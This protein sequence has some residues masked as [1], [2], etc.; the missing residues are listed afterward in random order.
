MRKN[1]ASKSGVFNPLAFA[2]CSVGI[3]LA[4]FSLAASPSN[5][6][7]RS[8]VGTTQERV[9]VGD[10]RTATVR[11]G[12][13]ATFERSLGTT[14]SPLSGPV[15]SVVLAP[16]P[17]TAWMP[18]DINAAAAA[19]TSGN[20]LAR[21]SASA[22]APSGCSSPGDDDK[23]ED[24]VT[25][26]AP[27]V[28]GVAFGVNWA[29]AATMSPDGAVEYITGYTSP[30]INATDGGDFLTTAIEV[31]TGRTLWQMTLD[32]SEFSDFGRYIA[33]SPDGAEVVVLGQSNISRP[34][35]G[36]VGIYDSDLTVVAYNAATGQQLWTATYNDAD[37]PGDTPLGVAFSADSTVAVIVGA[38][39]LVS[40][41]AD[42]F[43]VAYSAATGTLQWSYLIAGTGNQYVNNV[44]AAGANVYTLAYLPHPGEAGNYD[45]VATCYY[46]STGD[47]RWS[48]P[49]NFGISAQP[50]GL[51]ID[52]ADSRLF[53]VSIVPFQS[54]GTQFATTAYDAAT[55][56]NLWIARHK[57]DYADG[58]DIPTGIAAGPEITLAN[59][60]RQARVYVTGLVTNTGFGDYDFGTIAYDAATGEQLFDARYGTDRDERAWAITVSADGSRVYMAGRNGPP[61]NGGASGGGA[62]D[63]M[64]ISYD[65]VTGQ[66][67]WAARY[68][69]PDGAGGGDPVGVNVSSDGRW[70]VTA[71]ALNYTDTVAAREHP[72]DFLALGYAEPIAPPLV[73]VKSRKTHGS[74]GTFDVD[75]PLIGTSGIECRS[76]GANGDYKLV[77]TFLNNTSV[78][79]VS[80]TSG[81]G[82]VSSSSIG[83]NPN[84]YTVNL[85]AV[86]NA[87]YLTVML[88]GALDSTGNRG[89]V[90]G[91]KMGVL[92]GDV[93]ASG[94]V[95]SGDTNLCK[96]Q[97]LQQVTNTNFRN[98]I[99]ASGAITTGDVNLIKQNA[100]SHL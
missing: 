85:T 15:A 82:T 78:A 33:V 92:V 46:S 38:V 55:G 5:G 89:N 91:P 80:V 68:S 37:K 70:V 42:G 96:A 1:S 50:E 74:A 87:Q 23:C 51:A 60:S 88:N 18:G 66:Q 41:D 39:A 53:A 21:L 48:T 47:V 69:L 16:Q 65:G 73:S 54:N 28:A 19:P 43:V 84:Q 90:V 35:P 7:T 95:T 25:A 59:G 26:I 71:G 22:I 14:P 52:P 63:L 9:A 36:S 83:P 98:D 45:I 44:V 10:A 93:N 27:E 67:L 58:I 75:L 79:S 34:Q 72:R 8:D 2:L 3:F 100:L 29:F 11:T 32:V 24:W 13:N 6:V 49:I 30:P 61:Y 62:F 57:G 31:A 40:G 56:Q 64:T 17:G 12:L 20:V 86:T 76:G 97:A 99:N 4:M 94:V 77:F 81:A